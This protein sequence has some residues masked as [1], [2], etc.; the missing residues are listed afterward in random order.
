MHLWL[1]LLVLRL[2]SLIVL[3]G[4]SFVLS[5]L[6]CW[7]SVLAKP[8]VSLVLRLWSLIVVF[9][10]S[11]HGD[12]DSRNWPT[13]P[14]TGC[15][16]KVFFGTFPGAPFSPFC[17]LCWCSVCSL[18]LF[19]FWFLLCIVASINIKQCPIYWHEFWGVGFRILHGRPYRV[20][21]R[22]YHRIRSMRPMAQITFEFKWSHNT[23][24]ATCLGYQDAKAKG[25]HSQWDVKAI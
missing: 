11:A 16:P 17:C 4:A 18:S 19:F 15:L 20:T 1:D 12:K 7:C 6:T 24:Y 23:T 13:L 9:L 2:W 25:C 14:W 21:D 5:D 8:L 22:K 10:Q 3:S